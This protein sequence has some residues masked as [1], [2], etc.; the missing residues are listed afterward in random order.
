MRKG[1]ASN[2][3]VSV[4]ALVYMCAGHLEHHLRILKERYLAS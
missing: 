3:E 1:I 2:N 4:R